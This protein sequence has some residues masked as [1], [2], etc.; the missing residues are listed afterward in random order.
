MFDDLLAEANN[1]PR[2]IQS[3]CERQRVGRNDRLKT[4][5][6]SRELQGVKTDEFLLRALQQPNYQDPRNNLCVWARPTRAVGGMIEKVQQELRALAPGIWTTPSTCLHMTVLE[7]VHTLTPEEVAACVA[8]LRPCLKEMADWPLKHR[9]RLIK[10]MLNIDDGAVALSFVPA[11]GECRDSV[12][13]DQYTYLHL[14]N[15]LSRMSCENGVE[16]VARYATTSSH[17][18]VARFV[19]NKDHGDKRAMESWIKTLE[20]LNIW[21]KDNYHPKIGQPNKVDVD[22]EWY[23]GAER[24][25]EIRQ[26]SLWYGG[27]ETI[28]TGT[29]Y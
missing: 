14:R 26:G 6:L 23:I 10:P 11:A 17:M 19:S 20:A 12:S 29:A 21:L 4:Q 24:P 15:D 1:D 9:T 18:T 28:E 3:H 16:V 7:I 8:T 27:G 5:M 22:C 2:M 25:L 13:D